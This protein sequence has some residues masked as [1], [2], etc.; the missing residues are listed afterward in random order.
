MHLPIKS[1]GMC[2]LSS[3]TFRDFPTI[4][5]IDLVKPRFSDANTVH[6]FKMATKIPD[7]IRTTFSTKYMD[8]YFIF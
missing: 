4:F 2:L 3:L 6:S 8:E 5:K 1:D 7:Y